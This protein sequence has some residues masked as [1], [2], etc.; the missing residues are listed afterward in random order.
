MRKSESVYIK[1]ATADDAWGVQ[2]V[3]Y[4]AWLATYPNVEHGV[5]VEDI[6]DRFSNRHEP[7]RIARRAQMLTQP[8]EGVT[9]L[10]AKDGSLVVGVCIVRQADDHNELQVLY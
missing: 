9:R 6:E 3:L 8:D 4:Q 7:E 1:V 10:I 2:E 5:S